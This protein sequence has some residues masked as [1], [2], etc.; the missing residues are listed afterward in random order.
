MA[1]PVSSPESELIAHKRLHLPL[2]THAILALARALCLNVCCRGI[3]PLSSKNQSSKSK[4]ICLLVS[5]QWKKRKFHDL[6]FFP[7]RPHD[8]TFLQQVVWLSVSACVCVCVCVCVLVF[9]CVCTHVYVF[10]WS[11]IKQLMLAVFNHCEMGGLLSVSPLVLTHEKHK[12]MW[13]YP[14]MEEFSF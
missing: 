11:P 12:K 6:R 2:K 7:E 1:L 14:V 4:Y 8:P 9:V 5:H 10:G 13:I 3:S